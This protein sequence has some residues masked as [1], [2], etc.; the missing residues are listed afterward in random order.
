[1]VQVGLGETA[2][3]TGSATRSTTPARRSRPHAVDWV[4]RDGGRHPW[5]TSRRYSHASYFK[6]RT[7]PYFSASTTPM[8]T[9]PRR[10]CLSCFGDWVN[11]PGHW[12]NTE[13]GSR[14]G[15]AT[16]R[17]AHPAR[18]EVDR[19]GA[20]ATGCVVATG[21]ARAL[22][23]LMQRLG[24]PFY[25]R[26]PE[27]PPVSR[28]AAATSTTE[29]AMNGQ[30]RARH[31][32]I[33]VH[34]GERVIAAG[35]A[36]RA[37]DHGTEILR[38]TGEPEALAVWGSTYN[39]VRQRS[40]LAPRR[41]SHDRRPARP[42]PDAPRAARREGTPIDLSRHAGGRNR[43]RDR[44]RARLVGIGEPVRQLPHRSTPARG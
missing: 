32:Y 38:L 36:E 31:L 42:L 29:C 2:S 17:R 10:G 41:T 39:R 1:M 43:L 30:R 4:E 7:H 5:C 40:D 6:A 25:P 22:G 18:A 33:T 37:G 21:R 19:P 23:R 9:G 16:A 26:R 13:R 44:L 35:R 8:A 27:R 12:G 28:A 3:P 15:S 11:W 20:W 34:D 14:R 24:T